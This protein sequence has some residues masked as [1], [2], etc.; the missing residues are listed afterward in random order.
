MDRQEE[1]FNAFDAHL[2]QIIEKA[3]VD[4]TLDAGMETTFS[5]GGETV[6]EEIVYTGQRRADEVQ[7]DRAPRTLSPVDFR[8]SKMWAASDTW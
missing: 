3:A 5:E 1:V 8:T 6:R 4:G 7:R 2:D